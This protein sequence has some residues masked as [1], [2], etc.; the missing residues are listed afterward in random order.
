MG[1]C[2]NVCAEGHGMLGHSAALHP[3]KGQ[4]CQPSLGSGEQIKIKAGTGGVPGIPGAGEKGGFV[5]R[6]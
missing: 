3:L 4:S 6:N 1:T 5:A 2:V